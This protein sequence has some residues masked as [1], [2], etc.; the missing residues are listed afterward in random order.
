[1]K[2]GSIVQTKLEILGNPVGTLGI[3]YEEYNL[4]SGTNGNAGEDSY[5]NGC[6]VI[7]ANGSLDGFSAQEQKDFLTDIGFEPT[8]ASYKFEGVMKV[9]DDFRRGIWNFQHLNE[10]YKPDPAEVERATAKRIEME[11][12]WSRLTVGQQDIIRKKFYEA[13]NKELKSQSVRYNQWLSA[14][15]VIGLENDQHDKSLAD[16][17]FVKVI[18]FYIM[19]PPPAPD[20]ETKVQMNMTEVHFIDSDEFLD[21]VNE[22]RKLGKEKGLTVEDS[23]ETKKEKEE[24]DEKGN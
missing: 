12:R 24:D 20:M 7:F 15:L 10:K 14:E 6:S 22:N 13:I 1:M 18:M 4:K 23:L 3:C 8:Y 11:R 17:F 2:V 5:A 19:I 9:S 16:K 21:Q